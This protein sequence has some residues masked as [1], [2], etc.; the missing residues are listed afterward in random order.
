MKGSVRCHLACIAVLLCIIGCSE[1][2]NIADSR[3]GSASASFEFEEDVTSQTRL[4]LMGVTGSVT[5]TGSEEAST[6]QITGERIVESKNDADATQH[7]EELEVRIEKS[8]GEISITTKQPQ[9][10]DNRNY[11][12]DY[13]VI[14]PNS[15]ETHVTLVTGNVNI[16]AMENSVSINNV[17]GFVSLSEFIGNAFITSVTGNIDVSATLPE[18]GTFHL[19]TVTGGIR[20]DVPRTTSAQFTAGVVTGGIT[21]SGIE[22]DVIEDDP[23]GM[24]ATLGDGGGEIRANVVTGHVI[25][26]GH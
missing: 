21:V 2:N 5:I 14:L 19:N 4:R 25:L 23:M 11:R 16:N 22:Y 20:I 1:V 6:V 18:D 8:S 26:K 24:R 13:T 10:S 17:T 7:L 12:V 3:D 9:H 15:F